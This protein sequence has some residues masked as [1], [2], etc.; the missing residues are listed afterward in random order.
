M[1]L[2]FFV[3]CH[4]CCIL[5]ITAKRKLKQ[6]IMHTHSVE[7]MVAEVTLHNKIEMSEN[8]TKFAKKMF[9]IAQNWMWLPQQLLCLHCD[10]SERNIQKRMQARC[11]AW[12]AFESVKIGN[13]IHS[14]FWTY[15]C[16]IPVWNDCS[17]R[18]LQDS[19][20]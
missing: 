3:L 1:L 17:W 10:T 16:F 19:R 6:H 5:Y 4:S 2:L 8:C 18:K 15:F 11:E 7:N 14:H 9:K 13:V 12:N 20:F